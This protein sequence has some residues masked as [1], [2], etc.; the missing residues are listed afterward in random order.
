MK[1]WKRNAIA[2]TILVLICAGVYLNWNANQI[3]AVDFTETLNEE[4]VLNDATLTL[5]DTSEAQSV[6]AEEGS[7]AAESFAKIRLSRQESRDSA[8]ATLQETIVYEDGSETASAAA[9][10]LDDIVSDALAE[11]QIESLIIAKGYADCVAYMGDDTIDVAVSA[12]AEGLAE[13]DVALIA[14]IVT[15]QSDYTYDQIHII[16]VK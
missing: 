4:Q 3:E 1:T 10:S 6:S 5:S 13:A 8:V 7:S 9:L 12:P 2:A 11:S 16:E 15:A 14:D